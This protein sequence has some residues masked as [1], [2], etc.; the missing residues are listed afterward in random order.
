MLIEVRR[1]QPADVAAATTAS[2][3]STGATTRRGGGSSTSRALRAPWRRLPRAAPPGWTWSTAAKRS[4]RGAGMSEANTEALERL[5]LGSLTG[6]EATGLRRYAHAVWDW[7][8]KGQLLPEHIWRRRHAAIVWL[9]WVH[10]PALVAFGLFQG[11]TL[12]HMLAEGGLIAAAAAFASSERFT[13]TQRVVRRLV[14]P[15]HVLG[16]ARA[17][18]GRFHRGPL[19]LLRDGRRADPLPGMGPVPRGDRRTSCSITGCG[20]ARAGQRLQPPRRCRAPVALGD[21]PRRL[22]ARRERRAHRGL[23][24][25]RE[26]A[27]A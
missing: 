27:A 14:R 11:Q 9:L 2:S 15:D 5:Q 6:A 12:R 13:M 1:L 10:V 16:G 4:H 23:A 18:L 8:P 19:P 20:C 24:H 22:R 21:D 17:P 7:L 26:P 25:Q 3:G